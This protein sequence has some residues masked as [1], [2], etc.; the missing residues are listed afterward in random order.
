MQ[1]CHDCLVAILGIS[2]ALTGL[3]TAA[4]RG[5]SWSRVV[6]RGDTKP[7][8]N[9]GLSPNFLRTPNGIRTRAAT[10]K[11]WC[12]RPLDDGGLYC[13]TTTICGGRAAGI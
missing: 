5:H 10:L 8:A 1:R 7:L 4:F 13:K 12:P 11:G 9:K 6:T 2:W 3:E